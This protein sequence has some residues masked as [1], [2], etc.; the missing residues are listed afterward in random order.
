MDY[1]SILISIT[2]AAGGWYIGWLMG[3]KQRRIALIP[4]RIEI[5]D[6]TRRFLSKVSQEARVEREW[7]MDLLRET[8][9]AEYFFGEEIKSHI[10]NLYQKGLR[11]VLLNDTHRIEE[12]SQLIEWF[13]KQID[14]TKKLFGKYLNVSEK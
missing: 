6:A 1:M 13:V 4:F 5:H 9:H 10:N 2:S 3:K 7:L 12:A 14:E 11:W 8:R